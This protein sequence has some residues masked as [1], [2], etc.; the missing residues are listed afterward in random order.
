MP[1]SP[2]TD[3]N[4]YVVYPPGTTPPPSVFQQGGQTS[5]PT[6]SEP[7][8][9]TLAQQVLAGNPSFSLGGTSGGGSPTAIGGQT[10]TVKLSD[11]TE[12][13]IDLQ[14][15]HVLQTYGTAGQEFAQKQQLQSQSEAS[16]ASR[17]ASSE[18]AASQRQASSEAAT[19]ARQ[20][21]DPNLDP[22]RQMMPRYVPP[23]GIQGERGALDILDPNTG[24]LMSV[25]QPGPPP[26][27]IV[28]GNL[29]VDP[30]ANAAVYYNGNQG[31]PTN[32]SGGPQMLNR[33]ARFPSSMSQAQQIAGMIQNHGQGGGGMA[34]ASGAMRGGAGGGGGNEVLA[35]TTSTPGGGGGAGNRF[36]PPGGGAGP[37]GGLGANFAQPS[38][39]PPPPPAPPW[40][41]QAVD[42]SLPW[43]RPGWQDPY[44]A[45]PPVVDMS[46]YNQDAEGPLYNPENFT[47]DLEDTNQP[48]DYERGNYG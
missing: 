26:V 15:G 44:N 35:A 6:Q 37:R 24:Q 25:R 3:S 31:R 21:N 9:G 12:V 1:D 33:G 32:I 47:N 48:I 34:G 29:I 14:D 28:G 45:L 46:G 22:W 39:E 5:T 40:D 19:A 38:P 20:Q 4:G 7:Q 27:R 23:S 2:Y 42:N 36:G 18:A 13:L 11:G 30:G 17:E 10:Q 41:Q 16:M 8:A 43:N